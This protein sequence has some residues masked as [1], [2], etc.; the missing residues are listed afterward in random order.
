[1]R[2]PVSASRIERFMREL[3]R[4]SR[5]SG[6]VYLTGGASSVLLGWRESTLDVDISILP[7]D[8]RILRAL[9]ELKER[10]SLNVELASPAD[11][12]PTL[13]GWEER[14]RFIRREEDLWFHHYDFYAQCLAK[15]ERGHRKDRDDVAMML[16]DGLVKRERVVELFKAIAPELFR[17]PAIDPASFQRAVEQ[18][19]QIQ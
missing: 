7:E 11:F 19:L 12:I 13:P 15:I 4:A 1:M 10:L 2:E 18:A 6:R 17:Y 16:R 3:A 14:S 8:D 9:P 5:A